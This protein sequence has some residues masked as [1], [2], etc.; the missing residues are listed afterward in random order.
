MAFSDEGLKVAGDSKAMAYHNWL[1]LF[2]DISA[3][4]ANVQ[5]RGSGGDRKDGL[6]S[7]LVPFAPRL[8]TQ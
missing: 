8:A 3:A 6:S 1:G 2:M 4:I 5:A 7:R